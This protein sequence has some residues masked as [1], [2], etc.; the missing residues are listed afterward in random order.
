MPLGPL[1]A[2]VLAAAWP[3]RGEAAPLNLGTMNCATYE[4]DVLGSS[5]PQDPIDTVMWLFGFS[6]A[7]SGERVMYGNSLTA[8]GFALDA[9][10]KNNPDS[11]LLTAVTVVKSQRDNPMDLSRVDC[12]TF[13]NRHVGLR[14]SDPE[15]AK[16]LTM[17]LYGYAVGLTGGAVLDADSL[18]RFDAGLEEHC[19]A[20]PQ[21]TLFDALSARN[22]AVPKPAARPPHTPRAARPVPKTAVPLP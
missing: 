4:H 14:K 22:P 6:V 19:T 2:A 5:A 21:D 16:T 15:G 3:L 7:R 13:E 1:L 18:S 12:A 9:Q 20:F 10:C 17:W 11:T 8:F